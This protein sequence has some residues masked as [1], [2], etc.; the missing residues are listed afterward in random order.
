LS[1]LALAL[2]GNKY[3]ITAILSSMPSFWNASME[4][5]VLDQ[6]QKKISVYEDFNRLYPGFGSFLPEGLVVTD[7]EI[8][9][10]ED[11]NFMSMEDNGAFVWGLVAVAEV[12]RNNRYDQTTDF[13]L[14]EKYSAYVEMLAKNAIY[15]FCDNC[16]DD[17]LPVFFDY[18]QV[19]N[20]YAH[21][22][23]NNYSPLEDDFLD[24]PWHGEDAFFFLYFYANW[25]G[26]S[27]EKKKLL[28]EGK[29][30]W[31][32][33]REFESESG[34][35]TVLEAEQNLIDETTQFFFLPYFH[36]DIV[37][38]ISL[39]SERARVHYATMNKMPGLSTSPLLP[40][41][42]TSIESNVIS[43]LRA[44]LMFLHNASRPYGISWVATMLQG[45][46]MQTNVG[47]MQYISVTG[48]VVFV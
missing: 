44:K 18:L 15:M 36:I 29:Q 11:S 8:S 26:I 19:S 9:M 22:A 23:P 20:I 48:T 47:Y 24:K 37:R 6:L 34:N 27:P 21:P 33:S 28:W 39:N 7:S 42:D 13:D 35:I 14:S 43:P 25:S 45:P 46:Q 16:S 4:S 40:S 12:L 1:L 5:Y 41:H 30:Q 3:A 32:R 31:M 38:R 2:D 10:S 17:K